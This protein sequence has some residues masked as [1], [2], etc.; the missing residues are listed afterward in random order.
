MTNNQPS[1]FSE[2]VKQMAQILDLNIAPEYLPSVI[3]NFESIAAIASLVTEF[4]L[5]ENIEPA[6]VFE[7]TFRRLVRPVD[8]I[9]GREHRETEECVD[10]PELS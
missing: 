5:P 10:A 1:N 8:N 4:S 2:Y 9:F 7:P 6:P 3:E